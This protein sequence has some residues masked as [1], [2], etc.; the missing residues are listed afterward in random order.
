[1]P[2][3]ATHLGTGWINP[4]N[5]AA[6]LAEFLGDLTTPAADIEDAMAAE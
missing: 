2:L 3:E 4:D 6:G 5:R 1:V